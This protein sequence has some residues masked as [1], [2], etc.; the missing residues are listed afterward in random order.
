MSSGRM[1]TARQAAQGATGQAQAKLREQVGQR[2][3]QA[4]DL[5]RQQASDLRAAGETL[6]DQGMAGPA[7]AVDR[8]ADYA[9]RA[10]GYLSET[11]PD[12]LLADAEEFGRSRPW[13]VVA[14]GLAVGFAA[15]RVLKASSQER[16]RNRGADATAPRTA[17]RPTT[18]GRG[19]SGPTAKDA[20]HAAGAVPTAQAP[21]PAPRRRS[22]VRPSSLSQNAEHRM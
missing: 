19:P 8:L 4:S 18:A 6:R 11:E 10:G 12:A 20:S 21:A 7:K 1:E 22:S 9:Q 17:A 5:I 3:A 16:Y 14:G 13:A 2:S 15:S